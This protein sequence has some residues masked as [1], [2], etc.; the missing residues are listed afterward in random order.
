MHNQLIQLERNDM[1]QTQSMPPRNN[2]NNRGNNNNQWP[3]RNSANYQRP[4]TLLESANV[5]DESV[6]F[7]RPC[8]SFHEETTRSLARRILEESRYQ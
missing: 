2:N 5:V 4:P 3:K 1:M 7:Y 8:D 6:P